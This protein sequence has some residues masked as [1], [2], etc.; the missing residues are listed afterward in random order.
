VNE[1]LRRSRK[2]GERSSGSTEVDQAP[3]GVDMPLV[4][5]TEYVVG[6]TEALRK[7]EILEAAHAPSPPLL[8]RCDL[9]QTKCSCKI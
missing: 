3:V 4:A 1:A 7:D 2:D 5:G 8:S 9:V 6:A